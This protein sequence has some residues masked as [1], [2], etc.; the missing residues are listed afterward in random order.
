MVLK[1][2]GKKVHL[3]ANIGK[4]FCKEIP[5]IKI[6]TDIIVGYPTE[7]EKDFEK[8]MK[9]IKELKP[10]KIN[11]SRYSKRKGTKA[12]NLKQHTTQILK[13]RSKNCLK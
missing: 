4:P 10:H 5:N 2:T 3:C 11:I 13:E 6:T 12:E 9:I 1:N 7:T 8:T